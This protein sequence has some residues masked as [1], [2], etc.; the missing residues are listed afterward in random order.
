MNKYQRIILAIMVFFSVFSA[1]ARELNFPVPQTVSPEWQNLI[2]AQPAPYWRIRTLPIFR[3][4]RSGLAI[5]IKE[6]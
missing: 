6:L 5:S 3:N 2:A 4:G 1:E